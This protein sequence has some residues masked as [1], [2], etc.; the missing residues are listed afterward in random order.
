MIGSRSLVKCYHFIALTTFWGDHILIRRISVNI[1][2]TSKKP[3]FS[4]L[5]R[6]RQ[7]FRFSQTDSSSALAAFC[8]AITWPVMPRRSSSVFLHAR[9][10]RC[11]PESRNG[12]SREAGYRWSGLNSVSLSGNLPRTEGPGRDL[13]GNMPVLPWLN[14]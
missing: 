11:R 3:I 7:T 4:P 9:T 8:H 13:S 2:S 14:A 10:R 6:E 5:V 1:Y 12:L